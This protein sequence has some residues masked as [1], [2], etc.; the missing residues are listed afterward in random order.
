MKNVIIG[1]LAALIVLSFYLLDRDIKQNS[2]IIIDQ[3]IKI[4]EL[5]IKVSAQKNVLL[6]QGA[7]IRELEKVGSIKIIPKNKEF[8]SWVAQK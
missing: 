4:S 5:E 6:F 1:I 8:I 2:Q 3:E 7:R